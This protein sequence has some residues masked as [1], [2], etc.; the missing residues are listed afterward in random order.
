MLPNLTMYYNLA[1][2]QRLPLSLPAYVLLLSRYLARS[3]T[4]PV[5]V[6]APS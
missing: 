4:L 1:V 2:Q 5:K 3:R 6:S